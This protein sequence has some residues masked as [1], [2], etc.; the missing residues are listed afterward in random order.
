MAKPLESVL[1][2]PAHRA[3]NWTEKEILEFAKCADTVT[4]QQ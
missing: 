1:V 2:K 3:T 4:G